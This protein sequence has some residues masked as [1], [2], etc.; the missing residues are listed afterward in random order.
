MKS[1]TLLM[2]SKDGLAKSPKPKL[3]CFQLI[4]IIDAIFNQAAFLR[5]FARPSFETINNVNDFIKYTPT[6]VGRCLSYFA[7]LNNYR[8]S[9]SLEA[10]CSRRNRNLYKQPPMM[11]NIY[12]FPALNTAHW[13]GS[14]HSPHHL[15]SSYNRG[16]NCYNPHCSRTNCLHYCRSHHTR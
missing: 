4:E 9:T 11:Y 3:C 15:Q 7:T 6:C 14:R 10:E 8:Y 13:Q 5:L 2:V 16:E 12:W 1:L